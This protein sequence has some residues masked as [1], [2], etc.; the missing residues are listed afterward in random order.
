MN[1]L[2]RLMR[3]LESK[4]AKA[5]AFVIGVASGVL[6]LLAPTLPE[7][8]RPVATV[9]LVV[10]VLYF[11]WVLAKLVVARETPLPEAEVA[12]RY[13]SENYG[14][15]YDRIQVE[16]TIRKDGS[17]KVR[18]VG[19]VEA[20]S[21]LDG[22]DTFLLIPEEAPGEEDRGVEILSVEPLSPDREISWRFQRGVRALGAKL[23][24]VPRLNRGEKFAYAM[25][26]H[27]FGLYAID[28]SAEEL[29]QRETPFEYFG[30]TIK[31]PTR[32]LSLKVYFPEHIKPDVYDNEV[33]YASAAPDIL[34]ESRV[35]YEAQGSL[36]RPSLEGPEGGRYFLQQNVEYPIV[37]LI[38]LLRWDP[39]RTS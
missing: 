20:Y 28:L 38:Y 23:T 3:A 32:K 12:H 10:V 22:I 7:L 14:W 4:E 18:R 19:E 6:R 25:E 37:G 31:R 21:Q 15:A 33:R 35:F 29:A 34:D 26:E 11:L 2:E 17:A 9:F 8:V 30:W 13:L 16:C 27:L 24:I 36:E 5:I 39:L 1:L